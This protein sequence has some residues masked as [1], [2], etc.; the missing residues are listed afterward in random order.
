MQIKKVAKRKILKQ[1]G[2]K[3]R[4]LREKGKLSQEALAIKVGIERNYLS[5]LENGERSPSFYCL[6]IIAK[7]LDVELAEIVAN[8]D[9]NG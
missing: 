6:C 7:S 2:A 9:F 3:I 1:L 4:L 5:L 8:I